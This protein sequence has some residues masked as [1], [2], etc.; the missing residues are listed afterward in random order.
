MIDMVYLWCD[1]NDPDFIERKMLA[2]Q[3]YP[4][5]DDVEVIGDKRFFDNEELKYSLRSLEKFAPWINHVYI[6]TDRQIPKWLNTECDSITIIDHSVIIPKKYIPCFNSAVIEYFI[7][8]IPGLKEKFLYGNDDMFFGDYV[9]PDDFFVEDKPIVRVKTLK[10]TRTRYLETE[11]YSYYRTVKNSLDLLKSRY[12][13]DLPYTLHHN[14]DA[15]SKKSFLLTFESFNS[16]LRK[17]FG[18][19]FRNVNDIQRVLFNLDVVCNG[20]GQLRVV[21]NPKPWRK[22]LH[23]FK[24]VSWESYTGIDTETSTYQEIMKYKPKLFCLNSGDDLTNTGKC[25]AKEY[26]EKLFPVKSRFEKHNE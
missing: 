9:F 21:D 1:G 16:E 2:Q 14:I 11:E 17:C 24:S 13:I 25:S 15:Y 10:L 8:F 3:C 20:M 26:L 5:Q 18:N 23:F 19:A 6:V 7:A 12:N 22:R 4:N